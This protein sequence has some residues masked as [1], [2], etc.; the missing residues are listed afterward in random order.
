M[1]LCKAPG[2]LNIALTGPQSSG[3]PWSLLLLSVWNRDLIRM[4]RDQV[5][6]HVTLVFCQRGRENRGFIL[7]PPSHSLVEIRMDRPGRSLMLSS[8]SFVTKGKLKGKG[9]RLGSRGI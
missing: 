7:S 8:T 9:D 5:S 3:T 1:G 6:S 4:Q 2:C